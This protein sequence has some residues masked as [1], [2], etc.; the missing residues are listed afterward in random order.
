MRGVER[1]LDPL[2]VLALLDRRIALDGGGVDG[3]LGIGRGR[4]GDGIG[5]RRAPFL[6]SAAGRTAVPLDGVRR[7][8]QK[9]RP[10][11]GGTRWWPV[12]A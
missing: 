2:A 12:R 1:R 3:V 11:S 4:R 8:G 9:P 7:G 5:H 6:P 10:W